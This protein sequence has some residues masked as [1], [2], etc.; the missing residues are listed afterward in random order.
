MNTITINFFECTPTPASGYNLKWRILGSGDPY[1]D[2]GNFFSS[3][4]VFIDNINP[5][6]TC[7]EGTLQSDC[8]ESGESGSLLGEEI[9]WTTQCGESGGVTYTIE[10]ASPCSGILSNYNIEGGTPGDVLVVRATFIGSIAKI[11][12]NFTRADLQIS[13]PDG[14]TGNQSSACYS[15]VLGHF[16]GITADTTIIMTGTSTVVNL[17]AVVHN[18]SESSTSV[19][20][21]IMTVNGVFNGSFVSGCRGNSAT[22][23]TC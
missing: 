22:G 13:S 3:P 14:T 21:T 10:L 9:P 15:D 12:G 20:V 11:G 8:S 4:V 7:Y 1:T 18:S 16:I 19:T 17:S 6:G 2:E 5:E 23:G